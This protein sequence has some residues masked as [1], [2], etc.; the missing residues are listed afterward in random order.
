MCSTDGWALRASLRFISASI[1]AWRSS[2]LEYAAPFKASPKEDV[3]LV[4][5]AMDRIASGVLCLR[6]CS[7]R[8][9]GGSEVS[10]VVD[11]H[12]STDNQHTF[13]AEAGEGLS[14]TIMLV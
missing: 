13:V 5:S 7:P 14:H 3:Y 6:Q 1:F 12:S 2:D 11:R 4:Q 8:A 9:A 10:E